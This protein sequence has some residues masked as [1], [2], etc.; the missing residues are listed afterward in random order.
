[1]DQ[2]MSYKFGSSENADGTPYKYGKLF[3]RE[4]HPDWSR[5]TFTADEEQ[6]PLMLEIAARW[7]GPYGILYKPGR[8]PRR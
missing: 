1:M 4:V 5:V 6:I 2:K 8:G 7:G 3:R